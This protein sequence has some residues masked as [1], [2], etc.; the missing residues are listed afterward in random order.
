LYFGN[1][2]FDISIDYLQK[3]I[4]GNDSMRDDLQCYA[5]LMHLMA[6][7]ELGNFEIIDSLIRSVYRFMSK[8]ENLTIVE[9]EM[10]K[11]LRNSFQVHR[12]K[13]KPAFQEL[14]V[15]LKKLEKNRFQ[16]R[17]F[18][19][20]DIISWIESKLMDKPMSQVINEKYLQHKKRIY[21]S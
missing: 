19:Y 21:N 4:Y 13:L 16:T 3:I 17:S 12:Q 7:Y 10:F 11:F 6:H 14:L 20:L 9:Q 1:G 8:K 2:D 5:R 15:S 18:A